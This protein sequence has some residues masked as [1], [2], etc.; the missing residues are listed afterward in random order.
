MT[1]STANNNVIGSGAG[2]TL[3]DRTINRNVARPN[4][5]P[6]IV[7]FSHGVNDPGANY[8]TVEDGL[9]QGLNDRLDRTDMLK[10]VYGAEYKAVIAAKAKGKSG[11][12]IDSIANDPDT[13]LYARDGSAAHS[14]FIP[15]YW[16]Y[17]ASGKDILKDKSGNPVKLRSQ[18]QDVRGNRLDAHFAK[19]GGM[20][21]NATVS[22]PDMYGPGWKSTFASRRAMDV[23]MSNY[24]Y[25]GTSPPRL[26][27]VMAAQ[28][29]AMLISTIRAVAPDET[30]TVMA[31]SQGTMITL[32]AQA[33][34]HD[35]GKRYADCI[36][37]VDSPY[38]FN[39]D[40]WLANS[41]VQSHAPI[42]TVQA[43]LQ[44]LVNIVT[45]CTKTPY[46]VPALSELVYTNP[47]SGGRAGHNWT[48]KA[49]KRQ[50]LHGKPITFDERDNRGRVYLYFCPS[51][52]TVGLIT[53][54]GIGKF[55]IPDT[56]DAKDYFWDGNHTRPQSATN[57]YPAMNA[58][59]K[60]N[61]RQR[62]WQEVKGTATPP[63]VGTKPQVT[64]IS[65]F[66]KRNI[67]GDELKPA[68]PPR[69]HGGEAVVGDGKEAPDAVSQD[70][71]LGNSHAS[72]LWKPIASTG[73]STT[74][75]L[76]AQFNAGKSPDDQTNDVQFQGQGFG[77]MSAWREETAN[78]ARARMSQNPQSLDKNDPSE[79]LSSNSYHSAILRD[80]WNQRWGTSMD[81][82]IGQAKTLDSKDWNALWTA[83]AD[84][85]TPIEKL[86]SLPKFHNLKSLK[87]AYD[88]V[89]QTCDY[90]KTGTLPPSVVSASQPGLLVSETTEQ[91][92]NPER[93]VTPPMNWN[94]NGLSR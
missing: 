16:G 40:H 10:G 12:Q 89:V 4:D 39:E 46:Q 61:F 69:M 42:Q 85:K 86:Q 63:L 49:G 30:I 47:K 82:A 17:R 7:I 34:L 93:P 67:N 13:Y 76:K 9:C 70:L 31:H 14:V 81:V 83:I 22:L 75:S 55:G 77:S 88:L 24:Q 36:I 43:K 23:G 79:V 50:D 26:Y 92:A 21:N 57:T 2:V 94:F 15:F 28:R 53:V 32:L 59:E 64:S 56:L 8:E 25:S 11:S 6:G 65:D 71:A 51:D 74:D 33:M 48:A 72:F 84:W 37:L 62:A 19:A 58:L 29:M 91:R 90:Y 44:T 87:D 68:F 35:Q 66:G 73:D 80:P 78:E 41:V 5:L 60:V 54:R 27:Q 18:Y 38:S 52:T 45:E 1:D 3:P 20:F